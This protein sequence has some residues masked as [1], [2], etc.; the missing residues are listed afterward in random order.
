MAD[1]YLEKK[2]EELQHGRA[3]VRRS[4]PSLD[5]LM[6]SLSGAG[7]P[8]SEYA[9]KQA[10]LDAM[11]HTASIPGGRVS[12]HT[13]ETVP[14]ES[15]AFVRV[16]ASGDAAADLGEAVLALRLKAAELHLETRVDWSSDE[17]ALFARVQIY[18]N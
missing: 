5:S 18:R 17:D 7:E 10:Q 1:N 16:S 2:Y 9:V 12:F 8:S 14:G 3:V 13:A 6:K 11:V 4:T 15:P